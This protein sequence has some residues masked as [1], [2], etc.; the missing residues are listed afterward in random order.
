M[1]I[2]AYPD[3]QKFSCAVIKLL[4]HFSF[5][6]SLLLS[7]AF[8][9]AASYFN[10]TTQLDNNETLANFTRPMGV[11][12]CKDH[13]LYLICYLSAQTYT[14]YLCSTAEEVIYTTAI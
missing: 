7:R 6:L 9:N 4:Y 12:N 2:P 8:H 3:A 14:A 10:C 13:T 11:K 1:L 5:W